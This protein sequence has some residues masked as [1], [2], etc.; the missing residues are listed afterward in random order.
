MTSNIGAHYFQEDHDEEKL[1]QL[2][3]EEVK[4]Y[5]RPELINRIDEI[6]IFHSLTLEQ[7]QDIVDPNAGK[8]PATA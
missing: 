8:A 3:L 4:R 2:V 5:F 1:R 6:I 7:M